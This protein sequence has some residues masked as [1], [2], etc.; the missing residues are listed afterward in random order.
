MFL[1]TAGMLPA[2]VSC[3]TTTSDLPVAG[4]F[5]RSG[6][7]VLDVSCSKSVYRAGD[8]FSFTLRPSEDCYIAAWVV[9]ADGVTTPLYPNA[10][11]SGRVFRKGVRATLPGAG[12]FQFRVTPPAGREQLVVVAS[13]EPIDALASPPSP[14]TWMKG[15][16]VEGRRGEARIVYEVKP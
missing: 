3:N 4:T 16:V 13:T 14:G 1:L 7:I 2:L 12:D 6:D 15:I 10:L 8:V 5:Q 11:D 9:G